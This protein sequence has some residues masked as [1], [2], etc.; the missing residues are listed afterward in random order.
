MVC[1]SLHHNVKVPVMTYI[2]Y[3]YFRHFVDDF[4]ILQYFAE[5]YVLP[6]D[7]PLYFHRCHVYFPLSPCVHPDINKKFTVWQVFVF[8]RNK[9]CTSRIKSCFLNC[10]V[11][12]PDLPEVMSACSSLVGAAELADVLCVYFTRKRN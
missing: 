4:I 2:L 6:K 7:E 12:T 3:M 11:S 10:L 8:S 1:T 5:N 9:V